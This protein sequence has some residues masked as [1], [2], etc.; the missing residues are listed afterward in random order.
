MSAGSLSLPYELPRAWWRYVID[1]LANAA[2]AA[3]IG[4]LLFHRDQ[5]AAAM[6]AA[7]AGLGVFVEVE[8][9]VRMR[10][11]RVVLD[12]VGIA[13]VNW[14]GLKREIARWEQVT[15][16]EWRVLRGPTMVGGIINLDVTRTSGKARRVRLASGADM[17]VKR[18]LKE[19]IV[20][21]LHL[22]DL[23]EVPPQNPWAAAI[24]ERKEYQVYRR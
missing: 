8:R 10:K 4:W 6:I 16:V 18:A 12:E 5:G 17:A 3:G 20:A 2:W 14:I 22:R 24:I 23:T 11:T 9:R 19:A 21:R 1:C 7:W 13:R 15:G